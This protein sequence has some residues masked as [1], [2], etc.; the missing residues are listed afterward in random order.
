MSAKA[1]AKAPDFSQPNTVSMSMSWWAKN[2]EE[3][4][5]QYADFLTAT[6]KKIEKGG[7]GG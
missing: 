1:K 3:I 6:G 2:F 5:K 7:H 4:G